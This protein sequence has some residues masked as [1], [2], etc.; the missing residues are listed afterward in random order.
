MPKKI[1]CGGFRIDDDTL[2][3]KED[4][5]LY[6]IGGGS[7]PKSTFTL[8]DSGVTAEYSVDGVKIDEGTEVVELGMIQ[9]QDGQK[10]PGVS[11]LGEFHF[12][13]GGAFF[14]TG[15]IFM[16]SALSNKIFAI[17]IDDNGN[18]KT[19]EVQ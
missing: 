6:A 2:K 3:L 12:N 18:L 17:T 9:G 13:T 7:A 4:G 8:E 15:P 19:T 1:G 14:G 10:V 11:S 5:T 16:Q